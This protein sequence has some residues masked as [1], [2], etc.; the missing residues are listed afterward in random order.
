MGLNKMEGDEK[1]ESYEAYEEK[2]L[3][4]EIHFLEKKWNGF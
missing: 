3:M 1:A 4:F 2:A